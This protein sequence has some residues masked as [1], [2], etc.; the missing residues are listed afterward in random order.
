MRE[1]VAA[2]G[3]IPEGGYL[4]FLNEVGL[5]GKLERIGILRKG[6]PIL[7]SA[8]RRGLSIVTFH[9]AECIE[10]A[11]LAEFKISLNAYLSELV[12]SPDRTQT[13]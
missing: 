8:R 12:I 10:A 11:I 2:E 4:Q 9:F 1:T 13:S 6:F 5:K 3:F 7:Q